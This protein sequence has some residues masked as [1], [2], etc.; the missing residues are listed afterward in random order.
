M[1]IDQLVLQRNLPKIYYVTQEWYDLLPSKD[2]HAIYIIIGAK[3]RRVY[4]G[5]VL[6]VEE[7]RKPEYFLCSNGEEYKIYINFRE[8]Y[9]DRLIPIASYKDIYDAMRDL[10]RF[11]CVGSHADWALQCY[12]II[13]FYLTKE[14]SLQNM[15][16]GILSAMGYKNHPMLQALIEYSLSLGVNNQSMEP[17]MELV[18]NLPHFKKRHFL[19]RMY[20][21]LY[22]LLVLFDFFKD[23]KYHDFTK[24][25]DLS[26]F[27]KRLPKI[28]LPTN[29]MLGE[30][31]E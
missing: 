15:M 6:V 14:I 30:I 18:E 7:N 3:D 29:G 13:Y 1:L 21:D 31:E 25:I 8:N 27:I 24:D 22:D 20:S 2:P 17:C 4:H 23:P 5:E 11:N 28:L 10:N 26:E 9:V 16:I 19:F 12:N